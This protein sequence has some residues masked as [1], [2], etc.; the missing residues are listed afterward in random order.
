GF[1]WSMGA[2]IGFRLLQGLGAGAIQPTAMTIV[3]DLYTIDERR[4]TQSYM[5]TVWGVSAVIGPLA[6]AFIVQH[7]AWAWV[8]W[9]NAPLGVLAVVGMTLFLHEDVEHR[10][11]RIDWGGAGLFTI[12]VS[13]LLLAISPTSG[14]GILTHPLVFAAIAVVAA[15]A[16]LLCERRAPEPMMDV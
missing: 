12:A 11:R 3:S 15:P 2:L 7:W 10:S 13:A 5:A 16:F 4:R 6:G 8:F 9:I 14:G 1:S